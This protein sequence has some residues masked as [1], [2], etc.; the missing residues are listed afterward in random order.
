[1]YRHCVSEIDASGS[2]AKFGG[3]IRKVGR[4]F[5]I[6]IE[7]QVGQGRRRAGIGNRFESYALQARRIQN[8]AHPLTAVKCRRVALHGLS[9]CG[10]KPDGGERTSSQQ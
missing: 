5:K 2:A 4:D 10:K 9:S 6:S 8:F 3:K 1:M 7:L